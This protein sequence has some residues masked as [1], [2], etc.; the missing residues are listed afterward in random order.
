MCTPIPLSYTH[1]QTSARLARH[2]RRPRVSQPEDDMPTR[3]EEGGTRMIDHR[4]LQP[5]WCRRPRRAR[6]R[7]VSRRAGRSAADRRLPGRVPCRR[8]RRRLRQAVAA[9]GAAAALTQ[10][11]VSLQRWPLAAR[12]C[13]RG[14]LWE[15]MA[16]V[17]LTY[18]LQTIQTRT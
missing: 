11:T 2:R 17:I 1:R 9:A 5:P 4:S 18:K 16:L 13:R 7:R 3:S 12:V 14:V 6:D 8:R 10:T 15:T